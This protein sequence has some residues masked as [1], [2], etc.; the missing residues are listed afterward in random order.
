MKL[1]GKP[2]QVV[3]P[4]KDAAKR[5]LDRSGKDDVFTLAHL[6]AAL[7]IPETTLKS[8]IHH[9]PAYTFLLGRTRYFGNPAAIKELRKQVAA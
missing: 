9:L 3:L 5:F 2:F 8:A 6:S 1:N 7:K 4:P